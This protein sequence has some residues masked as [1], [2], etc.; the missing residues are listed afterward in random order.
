MHFFFCTESLNLKKKKSSR[1][2][3]FVPQ[4]KKKMKTKNRY[5]NYESRVISSFRVVA[6]ADFDFDH[7]WLIVEVWDHYLGWID[8][9][10]G[11]VVLFS[12]II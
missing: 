9:F 12:Y 8:S 3:S 11:K 6:G 1:F 5:L 7:S 2:S 10:I 4:K